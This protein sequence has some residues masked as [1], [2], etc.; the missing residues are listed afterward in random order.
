MAKIKIK[1]QSSIFLASSP[2]HGSYSSKARLRCGSHPVF[3]SSLLDGMRIQRT[4]RYARF[5]INTSFR[6]FTLGL[7]FTYF[8]F[9]MVLLLCLKLTPHRRK[10]QKQYSVKAVF[11]HSLVEI[12][13]S[14]KPIN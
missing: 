7:V 9:C 10:V 5:F 8:S 6:D 1:L 4:K 3:N 12:I 14:G 11:K 2:V 13:D